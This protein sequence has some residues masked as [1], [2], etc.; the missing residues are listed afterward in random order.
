MEK[1]LSIIIPVYNK[2]DHLTM[3]VQS[4]IDLKIDHSKIEALFIDDCS[5]DTS[6]ELIK[7]Y[8]QDYP[9]IKLIQLLENTGSPSEP[10]NRGIQEAKGKYLVFL[11]ADDWVDS[12]GFPKFIDKVNSDDADFGL[13]ASFKHTNK[14]ITNHAKFTSYKNESNMKPV[15]IKKL[16]RAVGPPG[17][18]FKREIAVKNNIQF[19]HMRFGED[20]LFFTELFSKV[21]TITMSTLPVYHVNRFD[22]NVSL[23]SGTSVMEKAIINKDIT[24]KICE[25]KMPLDLKKLALSRM[26]EVDFFRRV[27]YT[28]TFLNSENK[29]D[30]YGIFQE[31][32]EILHE[33][34]F[35]VEQFLEI[36]HFIKAYD[37]Y[38]NDNEEIFLRYLRKHIYGEWNYYIQD[39]K[40]IKSLDGFEHVLEPA[41]VQCYP[42]YEGTHLIDGEYVE[43]I[44]VLRDDFTTIKDVSLVELNNAANQEYIDFE[45]EGNKIL[46]KR[47]KMTSIGNKDINIKVFFNE[48]G[49]VLVNASYPSNNLH[50]KMKRQSFKLEFLDKAKERNKGKYLLDASGEILVKK[51]LNLYED[52][53]FTNQITSFEAGSLV[54]VKEVQYNLKG[55]PRLVTEDD[56]I[57]T[58]NK[59]F[60]TQLNKSKLEK[61]I[62]E[63]PN[64]VEV[65]K[66]CKLYDSRD[67][68]GDPVKTFKVGKKVKI[69]NIMFTNQSTPRLV[70]EDGKFMTAN[71]DFVKVIK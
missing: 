64:K 50:Y 34:G 60:V 67:F 24:R 49:S 16:F 25:L 30:F 56:K 37:L 9:F 31:V 39:E 27:F 52:L 47:E 41:P 17:K 61:Y 20:K 58:A 2:R 8:E 38:K 15:E 48:I 45:E 55:T 12:D 40:L 19:E 32:E 4:L 6:A 54:R 63:I 33:F 22:E 29:A 14:T 44:N 1:L 36:K 5:T 35:E 3:C 46:I 23:V 69:K 18:V 10:R 11:D 71:K 53:E 26:I 59:D 43:V 51:N 21:D 28:K 13:G 70:T 68:K 7:K 42:V 65:L 57:L 62:S 66:V